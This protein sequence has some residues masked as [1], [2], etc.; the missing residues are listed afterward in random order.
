MNFENAWIPYYFKVKSLYTKKQD[1]DY[2]KKIIK[3]LDR[4]YQLGGIVP[5]ITTYKDLDDVKLSINKL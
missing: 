5:L 4:I 1:L 2:D 3:Q